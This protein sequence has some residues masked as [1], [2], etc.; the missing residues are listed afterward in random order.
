MAS[1]AVVTGAGRGIGRAVAGA[2]AAAGFRVVVNDTG[3]TFEGRDADERVAEVAAREIEDRGGTATWNSDSVATMAGAERLIACAL[4][5]Y[6]RI[7]VLVN[8]AG[9]TRQNM[10][11]DMSEAD[12]DAVLA[13]NLKGQFAC[14]QAVAPHMIGQRSGSIVNMSSGVSMAGSVA[15]SNYCAS[16]A[17]VV[18]FSFATAMELGPFGVRVNAVFPAGH[19]RLHTKPEPWRDRYR[20]TERPPMP[21]DAWPVDA[22]LPVVV[23]LA[24]DASR[25]VNGQLFAAGG[26]TIGWY[27]TWSPAREV[28]TPPWTDPHAVGAAMDELLDGVVNPS[29][30][31][32][33]DVE[34]IVWPWVRPGALPGA[35]DAS[36]RGE[37]D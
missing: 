4:D 18:G 12:F 37:A 8:N 14:V 36:R 1:V 27:A 29:P 10:V 2:L 32:A 13:T 22:V 6:G 5:R 15:T 17:G 20:I 25:D 21:E 26:A 19:S 31:Q 34:D 16:K 33:G 7:D 3:G 28:A 9:I 23:Y 24:S 30:A 35:H 11:W